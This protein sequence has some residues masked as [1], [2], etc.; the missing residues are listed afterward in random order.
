MIKLTER[1]LVRRRGINYDPAGL[2]TSTSRGRE[3]IMFDSKGK[4]EYNSPL[5]RTL[6]AT[7][8]RLDTSPDSKLC[9]ALLTEIKDIPDYEMTALLGS[10]E[11]FS[12]F[13]LSSD[14][15]IESSNRNKEG[16]D[17]QYSFNSSKIGQFVTDLSQVG[18]PSDAVEL[19]CPNPWADCTFSRS[20]HSAGKNKKRKPVYSAKFT[21]T[22]AWVQYT[23]SGLPI[24]QIDLGKSKS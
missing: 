8:P 22:Q 10:S 3:T 21:P 2:R 16:R 6:D 19:F 20:S 9:F 15:R 11:A 23:E 14:L 5:V 13:G 4:I 18:V 7:C 17:Q 1:K 24:I 12:E